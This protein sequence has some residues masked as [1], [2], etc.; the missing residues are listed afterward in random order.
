MLIP[1]Q[2]ASAMPPFEGTHTAAPFNL[3]GLGGFCCHL[4]LISLER[5]M[6]SVSI[7]NSDT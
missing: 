5:E 6:G 3:G 7:S 1:Q 4:K 2:M